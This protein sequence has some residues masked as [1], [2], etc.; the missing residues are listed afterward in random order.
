MANTSFTDRDKGWKQFLKFA[1]RHLRGQTASLTVGVHSDAGSYPSQ[2]GPSINAAQ[3]AAFNEFGTE[4]APQRS[5]M[6]STFDE[7]A[8]GEWSD[9]IATVEGAVIDGRMTQP[10]ALKVIGLKVQSDIQK[11][12]VDLKVPANAPSTTKAKGSSNPLID[13]GHMKNSITYEIK[14]DR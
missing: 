10:R 2:S 13:T 4:K 12:I 9:L 7:K 5:F 11:K 3:V 8:D 1:R 6:R 14:G